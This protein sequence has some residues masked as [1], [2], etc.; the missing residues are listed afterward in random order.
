[1]FCGVSKL[2]AGLG[3]YFGLLFFGVGMESL[4]V[5]PWPQEWQSLALVMKRVDR[6]MV[7]VSPSCI[8]GVLHDEEQQGQ[9]WK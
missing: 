1:M 5:R 3:W 2:R 8:V 7:W 6:Q 9:A 4:G